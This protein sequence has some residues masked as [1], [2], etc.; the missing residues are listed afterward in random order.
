[1]CSDVSLSL[2]MSGVLMSCKKYGPS[3]GKHWQKQYKFMR[4][5]Y[6]HVQSYIWL[7]SVV[8]SLSISD[9]TVC[10]H[11]LNSSQDGTFSSWEINLCMNL[12]IIHITEIFQVFRCPL[13][14]AFPFFHC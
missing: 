8:L 2:H 6:K 14:V 4:S 10:I 1:M 12:Q 11:V 9:K 3:I 5:L 13:K 7:T